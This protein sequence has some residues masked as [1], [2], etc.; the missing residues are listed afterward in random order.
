M[1]HHKIK[2]NKRKVREIVLGGGPF[3]IDVKGGEK[4][5]KMMTGGA[6]VLQSMKKGEIV[7]CGW[8]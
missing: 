1:D 3:S 7:E 2:H 5:K 8:N 4:E 6:L